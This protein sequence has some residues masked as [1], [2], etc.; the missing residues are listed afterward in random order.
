METHTGILI[1]LI[2]CVA[3]IS[4]AIIYRITKT[5]R[6]KKLTMITENQVSDMLGE[7]LPEINNELEKLSNSNNIYKTI[8]CFVDFTKTLIY[9]GNLKEVKHCF[10]VA[11]KML[12]N[13][14]NTVKNAI[15]NVYVYSLGTVVAL[16]TLKTNHLKE[17][18]N[19][20]LREEY[21]KQVCS[22][23]I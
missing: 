18:F 3:P 2:A 5:E 4:L 20:S 23:G 7:E 6:N 22:S 10:N 8:E 16:S 9:K 17:I 11:E 1:I 12:E 14:N 13:G 15:E 19:G 21:N